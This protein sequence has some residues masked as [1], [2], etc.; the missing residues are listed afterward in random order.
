MSLLE[1]P[2]AL[3]PTLSNTGFF[4]RSMM[5]DDIP[6][7]YL[8]CR[9]LTDPKNHKLLVEDEDFIICGENE[10]RP[11][12]FSLSKEDMQFTN[13]TTAEVY[14]QTWFDPPEKLRITASNEC[15]IDIYAELELAENRLHIFGKICPYEN[16]TFEYIPTTAERRL[17]ISVIRSNPDFHAL[18]INN[19][20]DM[21]VTQ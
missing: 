10:I 14:L 13:E 18:V 3:W 5:T 7:D 1:I 15:W 9:V 8:G 20:K 16:Y 12:D 2:Q 21:E 19:Q 11:D 6:E 4:T 17:I